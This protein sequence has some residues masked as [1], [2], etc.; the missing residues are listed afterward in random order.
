MSRAPKHIVFVDTETRNQDGLIG[1]GEH[2]LDF[3]VAI[4]RRWER[5]DSERV[6]RETRLRFN[7]SSVFWKWLDAGIRQTQSVWVMAH[8]W[9]F[10]GAILSTIS[11]MRDAGWELDKYINEKPP[12]IIRWSHPETRRHITLVDTLNYFTQSLASLGAAVGL[13]KLAMPE[14]DAPDAEWDAYAWRDVEIIA[15]V[16]TAFR[17]MVLTHSLGGLQPTLASQAFASWRT[18]F[19]PDGV[20]IY[21]HDRA[22]LLRLERAAYHGGRT[23][24]H[25]SGSPNVKLHKLDINSHYPAQMVKR[26]FPVEPIDYHYEGV[27]VSD[28]SA[29]LY[30]GLAVTAYVRVST[31]RP[32]YPV[33]V[34]RLLFPTGT[35]DTVLTTPE[36]EFALQHGHIQA[37]DSFATY[38]KANIFADYVRFFYDMR[39]QYRSEG[40]GAFDY[41]CKILLNSLYGKFGQSGRKWTEL[42]IDL[43]ADTLFYQEDAD[44]E[45]PI[46]RVRHILG[47]TQYLQQEQE[48]ENSIPNIAAEITAAGRIELYRL[49]LTA[50]TNPLNPTGQLENRVYYC[51]TDSLVVDDVGL[52]R[53]RGHLGAELGA[54]KLEGTTTN[55]EFHAPKHYRFGDEWHIKG[56]RQTAERLSED[57]YRQDKFNSWDA[58]IKRGDSDGFILIEKTDKR[59]TRTNRKA[60]LGDD[61]WFRPIEIGEDLPNPQTSDT[62]SEKQPKN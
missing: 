10:D 51:D 31:D 11:Y 15:D 19:I 5:S 16:F 25:Y 52:D 61:S 58:H 48:S 17:E 40:K 28:L 7:E 46:L 54:L 20:D 22:R 42:G 12:V 62:L 32:A 56:I 4:S 18:R 36:I 13:D 41:M 14:P 47:Q 44:A 60:I 55:A 33:K 37:V 34:Q 50:C 30:A 27:K 8:N 53:L 59:L 38:R 23:E 9:N 6:T 26:E 21:V 2:R 57:T 39:Q 49:I 29:A 35:F 1:V 24:A 3:G 43:P 45:T